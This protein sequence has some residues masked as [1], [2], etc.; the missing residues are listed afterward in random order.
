V[1]LLNCR[2]FRCGSEC[3]DSTPGQFDAPCIAG[4]TAPTNGRWQTIVDVKS[5]VRAPKRVTG[6]ATR[7]RTDPISPRFSPFPKSRP[8]PP[9]GVWR[10][11]TSLSNEHKFMLL[12]QV[13]EFREDF[14]AWL[15]R[16]EGSGWQ[17]L[18]RLEYHGSPRPTRSRLVWRRPVTD[19]CPLDRRA[20]SSTDSASKHR[21]MLPTL[22]RA[23]FWGMALKYF[24]VI[25]YGSGQEEL[26]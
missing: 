18:V 8:A 24:R 14:K 12:V 6:E 1:P 13:Q 26:L 20:Q 17:V 16:E 10:S 5:P 3:F 23:G 4:Q 2:P 15:A 19:R 11:V 7:W 9:G 22:S 21:H 25:P